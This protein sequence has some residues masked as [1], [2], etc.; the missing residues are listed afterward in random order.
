MDA[1]VELLSE[2]IKNNNIS[3]ND[4]HLIETDASFRKYYRLSGNNTLI[5]DAPYESGE[6]VKSFQLI[7]KI[8]IEMGISAPVIYSIDENNGFILLE[9]LGD[10]IFSRILNDENEHELYQNAIGVLAH[11]YLESNKKEFNKEEISYYSIDTLLE[12]SNLFCDW[13]MEKHC[14]IALAI[15]EKL[16]YQ[17]ILKKLFNRIDSTSSSL[18]L[19]D[20]HVDNLI[21]LKDRK[22]INQVGVIDFQDAVIG[23][24]IYDLVSLL[25][26]VRRPITMELKEKLIEEYIHI[27]KYDPKRLLQEMRFF[28][29]QRNLKIIGIFSRLKYRDQK[30]Q[31][32]KLINNA[33]NF[34]YLH[35]ED[36]SFTELKSW[37]SGYKN[38]F[39]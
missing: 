1:R 7:D 37:I 9:D 13:F 8:L 28:S 30:P 5:M 12:E 14:K 39:L 15:E 22:G 2:F 35:L 6:S 4:M 3:N 23:S 19:R 20:Y 27:T 17:E 25:E 38:K 34:I 10:Q 33:W 21:L 29:I 11:I 32:M 36:P 26:D 31:Y 18:V 16:K 24:N